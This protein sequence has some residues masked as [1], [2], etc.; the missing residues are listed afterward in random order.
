M[1]VNERKEWQSFN[2][3]IIVKCACD[4]KHMIQENDKP[5]SYHFVFGIVTFDKLTLIAML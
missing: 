1:L 3:H 2:D 4:R 5:F